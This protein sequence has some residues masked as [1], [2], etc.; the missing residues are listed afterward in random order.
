MDVEICHFSSPHFRD[1]R[2]GGICRCRDSTFCSGRV[3]YIR[4]NSRL[5]RRQYTYVRRS[6]PRDEGMN[7][8]LGA[9]SRNAFL[10]PQKSLSYAAEILSHLNNRR[11]A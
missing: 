8:C 4:S 9:L 3:R 1:P 11:V 10:L 7:H 2:I 6:F 5:R